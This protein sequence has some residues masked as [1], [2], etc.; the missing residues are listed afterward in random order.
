[1]T[2]GRENSD[3]TSYKVVAQTGWSGLACEA[4]QGEAIRTICCEIVCQGWEL[5]R[6][7]K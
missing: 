1:M 3:K 2:A 4:R 5:A 6:V 7:G